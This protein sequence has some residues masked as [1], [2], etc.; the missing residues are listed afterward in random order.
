MRSTF[1]AAAVAVGLVTGTTTATAAVDPEPPAVIQTGTNEFQHFFVKNGKV[2]QRAKSST[3]AYRDTAVTG[4]TGF[5]QL[6][7]AV[8][9]HR[10]GHVSLAAV[11]NNGKVYFTSKTTLNGTWKA[12]QDLGGNM[13]SGIDMVGY[14]HNDA[15]GIYGVSGGQLSYRGQVTFDGAFSPWENLGG[16]E[17]SGRP[18]HSIPFSMGRGAQLAIRQGGGAVVYQHYADTPEGSRF[19]NRGGTLTGNRVESAADARLGTRLFGTTPD[20]QVV[21]S[22]FYSLEWTSLNSPKT[23]LPPE[24]MYDGRRDGSDVVIRAVDGYLY[25]TR[26]IGS[27]PEFSPWVRVSDSRYGSAATLVWYWDETTGILFTDQA[28]ATHVCGFDAQGNE[29]GCQ[30]LR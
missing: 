30:V 22:S 14:N 9:D 10:D 24:A 27:S 29:T 21:T 16:S 17:L 19:L 13:P 6:P 4:S 25:R 15:V 3:G 26:Q 2:M 28:G 7:V 18:T 8:V 1:I 23:S 12:F 20:G 5:A 11:K